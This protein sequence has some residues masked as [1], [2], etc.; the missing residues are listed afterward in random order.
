MTF[1]LPKRR[2]FLGLLYVGL[3]L[4]TFILLEIAVHLLGQERE[5]VGYLAFFGSFF[6]LLCLAYFYSKQHREVLTMRD[7]GEIIGVSAIARFTWNALLIAVTMLTPG[8]EGEKVFIG[9]I[10]FILLAEGFIEFLRWIFLVFVVHFCQRFFAPA[11]QSKAASSPLRKLWKA[12]L[13]LLT[14]FIALPVIF[15]T[16]VLIWSSRTVDLSH[17]PPFASFTG[18][19]FV[20]HR[21]LFLL[22]YTDA[23]E[24]PLIDGWIYLPETEANLAALQRKPS[25]DSGPGT[26]ISVSIQEY[27][28]HQG[29]LSTGNLQHFIKILPKGTK[30]SIAKI[31]EIQNIENGPSTHI[32]VKIDDADLRGQLA[33]AIHLFR[34]YASLD[35]RDPL[36]TK[37]NA[38]D[39]EQC[40]PHS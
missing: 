23:P 13:G 35:S 11:V 34:G 6:I 36:L 31:V 25:F 27:E 10:I 8:Q 38:E 24:K 2:L 22:T 28:K 18:T 26:N 40:S 17:T 7:W 30:L 19:C 37:P 14:L 9:G 12:V 1:S 29:T 39:L 20:L 33:D 3:E 21:D 32:L 16:F 15:V 5:M 4:L